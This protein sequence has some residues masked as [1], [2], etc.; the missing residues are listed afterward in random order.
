M[1]NVSLW[2]HIRTRFDWKQLGFRSFIALLPLAGFGLYL[3][4]WGLASKLLLSLFLGVV[5]HIYALKKGRRK[6]SDLWFVNDAILI[7]LLMPAGINVMIPAGLTVVCG[8]LRTYVRDREY[9]YPLNFPLVLALLVLA[10]GDYFGGG[11]SLA[12]LSGRG[13]VFSGRLYFISGWLPVGLTIM[14]S[15][16]FLHRLYKWRILLAGLLMPLAF[17][18]LQYRAYGGLDIVQLSWTANLFLFSLGVLG[19]DQISTPARHWGQYWYGMLCGILIFLFSLK[20]LMLEGI[21]FAPVIAGLATPLLDKLGGVAMR[22][23]ETFNLPVD[24]GV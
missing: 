17:L 21:L 4:G 18:Y 16:L 19:A 7:S 9:A 10:G 5:W 24:P 12:N 22:A 23:A 1:F 14:F 6:R 8:M 20:G 15:F 11:A 2:P 13:A 3:W